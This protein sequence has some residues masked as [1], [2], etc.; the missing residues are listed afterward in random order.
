MSTPYT[1]LIGWKSLN[2]YYYGSRYGKGCDPSD[3]WVKYFTSSK[4]VLAIRESQG[5]PD[6]IQVRKTFGFRTE[7]LVYEHTVLRRLNAKG[8]SDFLN[9]TNGRDWKQTSEGLRW[10]R[11][12]TDPKLAT[13]AK[14]IKKEDKMPEGWYYG[15]LAPSDRQ[16]KIAS[17]WSSKYRHSEETKQ[18]MR[19]INLGENNPNFGKKYTLGEIQKMRDAAPRGRNNPSFTGYWVLPHGVFETKSEAIICSPANIGHD[20][21]IKW[22][23]I[24]NDKTINKNIFLHS[25][26]LQHT[27]EYETC[28]GKTFRDLGF[29]FIPSSQER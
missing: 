22:C 7:A 2:L 6:I 20:T 21:I 9:R 26:Y 4:A 19:E 8:R 17:E 13:D 3:L 29:G 18:K 16:R 11:N 28:V 27:F 23:K 5:E 24:N 1:Y 12:H 10:I 15:F 14:Y 25:K